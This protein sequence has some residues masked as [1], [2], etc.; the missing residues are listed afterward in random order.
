[1]YLQH[2]ARESGGS[3]EFEKHNVVPE[4][5]SPPLNTSGDVNPLLKANPDSRPP[6]KPKS[7]CSLQ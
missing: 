4:Y 3:G 6:K 7:L 2:F 1:M 5:W